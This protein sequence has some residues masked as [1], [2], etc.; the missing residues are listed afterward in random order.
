MTTCVIASASEAIQRS[1]TA[2][3]DCFVAI[4]PRNDGLSHPLRAIVSIAL[5][6][7]CHEKNRLPLVRPLDTRGR[8]RRC[9]RR[10]TRSSSRSIWLSPPR[11]WAQ[12]GRTSA[13]ITF[14]AP[15]LRSPFPLLAAVGARTKRIE[16][17]TAIIDMRYENP[18]YMAE[19]AGTADVISG[20]RLQLGISRG[21]PEQMIDGWRYFGYAPEEGKTDADMARRHARGLSRG[22]ARRR[23]CAAQSA[24]DVPEPR[25]A[26]CALSHTP[27]ACA[28]AS[29]GARVQPPPPNGPPRSG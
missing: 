29:G 14:C 9:G 2:A 4:A 21:S 5:T 6:L 26:C 20:G 7:S 18:M 15:A 12:T 27:K 13:C 16:I 3:L 17:G 23:F 22:A 10:P 1:T 25:R 19:D 11:S 28:S 8:N 24:T